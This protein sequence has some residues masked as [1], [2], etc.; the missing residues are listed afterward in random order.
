MACE[1]SRTQAQ[2]AKVPELSSMR[3]CQ[4]GLSSLA[5]PSP[6]LGHPDVA[7]NRGKTR[8][9]ALHRQCFRTALP[10]SFGL[11]E[12]LDWI[13]RILEVGQ[14]ADM[15]PQVRPI[16]TGEPRLREPP[17]AALHRQKPRWRAPGGV[18]LSAGAG[19]SLL[20][21]WPCLAQERQHLL[22]LLVGLRDH[23][24]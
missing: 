19:A 2:P 5:P 12:T 4:A 18:F 23:R 11:R 3:G 9:R 16:R 6:V 20:P 7:R 1:Y 14:I 24:G 8:R 17:R 15:R 13:V 22:R 21:G 10:A